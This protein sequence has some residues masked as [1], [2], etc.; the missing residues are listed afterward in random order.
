MQKQ[1]HQ[2]QS[3]RGGNDFP[4]ME[5]LVL[6]EFL[7][8]GVKLV[9]TLNAALRGQQEAA[10]TAARVADGLLGFGLYAFNDGVNERS[11]RE[12]LA[13][14]GLRALGDALQKPLVD[15]PLDV[16]RHR[17]P[18]LGANHLDDA[19]ENGRRAHLVLRT[20]EYLLEHASLHTELI[21]YTLVCLE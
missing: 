21:E 17:G 1:I 2:A 16:L 5:R 6:Q 3:T 20:R 9:G 10:R 11:R 4:T 12:V 13:G 15:V 18:R 7:L 14:T 19:S 8:I